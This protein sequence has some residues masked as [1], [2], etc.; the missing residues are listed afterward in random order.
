VRRATLDS[1]HEGCRLKA[2]LLIL[3]ICLSGCSWFHKTTP[4]PPP[5]PQ[6]IV[7]GVPAGAVLYVDGVQAGQIAEVNDRTQVLD[8][9][10]GTHTLEV[11]RGDSVAY[12]E[13]AYVAAGDKRVIT[14]LSGTSRE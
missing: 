14:V 13:S 9:S 11:R 3:S 4:P 1:S 5:P 2:S 12:R 6:L 8:V 10:P 7:T